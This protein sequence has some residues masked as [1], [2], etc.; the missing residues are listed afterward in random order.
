MTQRGLMAASKIP[1][2]RFQRKPLQVAKEFGSSSTEDQRPE[3]A[4]YE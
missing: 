3:S 4:D 1:D 2:S